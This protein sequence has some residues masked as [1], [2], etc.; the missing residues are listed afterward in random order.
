[1]I[2]TNRQRRSGGPVTGR[3]GSLLYWL[4]GM[5]V[6]YGIARVIGPVLAR[7]DAIV[8]RFQCVGA[9]NLYEL[10]LLGV[11]ALL[12]AS[13]KVKDDAVSVVIL[14]GIMVIASGI[15][16]TTVAMDAPLLALSAGIVCAAAG[17]YRRSPSVAFPYRN[18]AALPLD[19]KR[20]S[21]GD[22]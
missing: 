12:A 10:A 18:Q 20:G 22:H 9:L 14:V 4:S 7:S 3:A 19:A 1:M 21:H 13:W 11:L 17:L 6:L 2:V 15:A 8:E 16:L 5:A